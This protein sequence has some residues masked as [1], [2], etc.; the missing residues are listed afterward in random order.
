[1][2]LLCYIDIVKGAEA[3]LHDDAVDGIIGFTDEGYPLV[4]SEHSCK[5]WLP[6]ARPTLNIRICWYCRYADFRKTF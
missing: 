6:G 5:N 3:M 4:L 1:M 2:L